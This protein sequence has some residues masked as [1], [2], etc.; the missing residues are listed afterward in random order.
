M[1]NYDASEDDRDAELDL[2]ED[3]RD[4]LEIVATHL[5]ALVREAD[6]LELPGTSD[7]LHD[8]VTSLQAIYDG[9]VDTELVGTIYTLEAG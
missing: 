6:A 9:D 4:R 5:T 1:P 2:L 7:Q 8:M 3:F